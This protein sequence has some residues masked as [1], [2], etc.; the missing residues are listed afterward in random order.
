MPGPKHSQVTATATGGGSVEVLF[1]GDNQAATDTANLN[2]CKLELFMN[3][4]KLFCGCDSKLLL[5]TKLKIGENAL[6]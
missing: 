1:G 5:S 6:F 3:Y 2:P 4:T